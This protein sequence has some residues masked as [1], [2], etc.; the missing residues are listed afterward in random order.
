MP[1]HKNCIDEMADGP[2]GADAEQKCFGCAIEKNECECVCPSPSGG[3]GGG[4][5]GYVSEG[6][7]AP[8]VGRHILRDKEEM[9][10]LASHRLAALGHSADGL[11]FDSA[12]GAL[13]LAMEKMANE[14]QGG[15]A[16]WAWEVLCEVRNVLCFPGRRQHR[17]S[18]GIAHCPCIL[19][20]LGEL[21]SPH[22]KPSDAQVFADVHRRMDTLHAAHYAARD[23][24]A[25]L[26]RVTEE[27]R[28]REHVLAEEQRLNGEA[29]AHARA[30]WNE[31][32]PGGMELEEDHAPEERQGE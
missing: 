4:S 13:T 6:M 29:L 25:E 11:I 3:G 20:V 15:H 17:P 28:E 14:P 2:A 24:R 26:Q 12:N 23:A 8:C 31:R 18:C 1:F 10:R 32:L 19:Q 22:M 16:P 5:S 9:G 30:F 27:L 21:L 7:C